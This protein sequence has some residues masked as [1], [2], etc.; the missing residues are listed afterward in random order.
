MYHIAFTTAHL[1]NYFFPEKAREFGGVS[2]IFRIVKELS[3]N[4][5]FNITC[6]VGDYGQKNKIRFNNITLIRSPIMQRAKV[7]QIFAMFIK[8]CPDVIIEF[9][10]SPMLFI[11][12]LLK[13][14]NHQKFIFFVGSDLDVNGDYKEN[15]NVIYYL[16]YKWG[17]KQADRVICQ[18]RNQA[19]ELKN[20]YNIDGSIILSPYLELTPP[21]NLKKEY[22]L[23][24]GRSAY[25]KQP[26]IFIRLAE[27]IKDQKF[28]MIC[29]Q[30]DHD[31]GMHAANRLKAERISN[32]DFIEIVPHTEI[33]E[34]FSKAKLLVNTSRFEG[35]P[36]TFI[37]AA[38]EK[39]P[40]LSLNVDPNGMLLNHKAG[41][42][43]R[44]SEKELS[45]R[46][47]L[48][49]GNNV[50]RTHLGENA[51]EYALRYHGIDHAMNKIKEMLLGLLEKE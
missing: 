33:K 9:Y 22:I 29:N 19:N 14:Y 8:Y 7:F 28:V 41:L 36:N 4:K 23:W 50:L 43:C 47:K 44:G 2:R 26:E 46:C 31:K 5:Q 16:L 38:I 40:V 51:R 34:Y 17:L 20:R 21:L 15:T 45:I 27:K 12:G 13:K 37:E 30:S 10:A 6:F 42:F 11:L 18:T 35:F 25:Y 48:L 32:L 1:Y 49:L 3:K 24:V 39:T